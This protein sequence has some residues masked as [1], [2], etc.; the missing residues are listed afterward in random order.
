[1][2]RFSRRRACSRSGSCP[3]PRPARGVDLHDPDIEAAHTRA[4]A[5]L[6]EVES[7]AGF[8]YGFV[9]HSP[10][11]VATRFSMV[12]TGRG[13]EV[14]L[15]GD[16]RRQAVVVA[17]DEKNDLAILKLDRPAGVAPLK[18][19]KRAST[20]GEPVLSIAEKQIYDEEPEIV[21]E[22]GIVT[23]V[24]D[25]HFRS[26]AGHSH[27]SW[28]GPLLDC[29]G[30]VIGM[31]EGGWSDDATPA[32]ALNALRKEIAQEQ[33][34][35]G[36]WSLAH[37]SVTFPIQIDQGIEPGF[38]HPDGWMGIGLGTALIGKDRW[39]FPIRASVMA[40]VG[41]EIETDNSSRI[42]GRVQLETG[43]GYRA[44]LSGGAIPLYLV[45][46]SASPSATIT[47]SGSNRPTW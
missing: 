39:F 29:S 42:G 8:G 27:Y 3:H 21:I 7:P 6:V 25:E 19:A 38:N 23:N 45:P 34:Y 44:M 2:R 36:D 11:H 33:I 10:E 4:K 32:V 24:E 43:I 30:A 18:A 41:P 9:F 26:D 20:V 37:P 12:D 1:M 16:R 35:D 14:V 5:A 13:I 31:S 40:L 17:Y 22:P 46:N 28:G 15:S 47:S